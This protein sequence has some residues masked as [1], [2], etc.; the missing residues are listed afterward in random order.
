MA[1]SILVP[2]QQE[3]GFDKFLRRAGGIANLAKTGVDAYQGFNEFQ[4][5]QQLL[6]DQKSGVR[7]AKDIDMAQFQEA[8]D[9]EAGAEAFKIRD[10][11]NVITRMY[12]KR[13]AAEK[14]KSPE[15]LANLAA[16]TDYKKA[17]AWA[18]RNKPS[19]AQETAAMKAAERAALADEKKVA[20]LNEVEDRRRNILDNVDLVD[21]M[22]EDKGTFEMFGS[23]NA[24]LDRRID[25]IATDM[26]KLADP[27]S[28]ARP[29][30]VEM[31]KKGLVESGLT[32]RNS[33]A[34]D[35][36]KNFKGEVEQRA[37]NAYE[38]RGLSD[39]VKQRRG[40]AGGGAQDSEAIAWAKANPNDPRSKSILEVNANKTMKAR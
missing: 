23:H 16:D 40:E 10:G 38:I 24:D 19:A 15:E 27:T 4:D 31:F 33:T 7:M 14:V 29:S 36:L 22:I 5:K 13:A 18:T 25:M 3:A 12:K 20:S 26:A 21:K 17:Q 6:D 8:A 30:E 34:R 35:L 1:V 37:S 9:G 32:R 28:V 2:Q 11:D 39:L